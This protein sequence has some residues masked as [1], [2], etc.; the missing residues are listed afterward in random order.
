MGS[1][2][3]TNKGITRI[4]RNLSLG[5][6][7][8]IMATYPAAAAQLKAELLKNP[9]TREE[10]NYKLYWSGIRLG[11][12]WMYWEETDTGYTARMQ[13]KFSG[14]ARWFNKQIR[15]AEINGDKSC[16]AETCTYTPRH[17]HWEVDYG[18]KQRSADIVYDKE[19]KVLEAS[20]MPPDNRE[21]RPDVPQGDKDAA[22]DGLTATQ[23]LYFAA[24]KKEKTV[25]KTY[26]GRRLVEL[27]FTPQPG[28]KLVYSATRKPLAGHSA[29]E[30]KDYAKGDPEVL[31]IYSNNKRFPIEGKADATIGKVTLRRE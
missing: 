26:D 11:K 5:A 28:D 31:L 23:A 3:I 30:L 12:V 27:S 15:N 10:A 14:V 6:L 4:L 22:F 16:I 19:G 17:L 25:F 7:I 29:K 18:H 2:M 1:Q 21:T 8:S 20:V 9:I 24:L 13:L